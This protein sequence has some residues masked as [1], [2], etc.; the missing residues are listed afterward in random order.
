MIAIYQKNIIYFYK[1]YSYK[2]IYMNAALLYKTKV[3][4]QQYTFISFKNH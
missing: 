2:F 1:H 4:N 3:F